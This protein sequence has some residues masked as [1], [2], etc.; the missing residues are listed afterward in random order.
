MDPLLCFR[1]HYDAEC[2]DSNS[3]RMGINFQMIADAEGETRL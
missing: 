1:Q 2:N 3:D